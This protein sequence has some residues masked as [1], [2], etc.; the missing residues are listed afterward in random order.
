MY[1]DSFQSTTEKAKLAGRVCVAK[2]LLLTGSIGMLKKTTDCS[3]TMRDMRRIDSLKRALTPTVGRCPWFNTTLEKRYS[4]SEV[5]S[6]DGFESLIVMLEHKGLFDILI[7]HKTCFDLDGVRYRITLARAASTDMWPMGT[8]YWLRDNAIIGARM[9]RYGDARR[10]RLGLALL[11][12][13]LSFIS[14]CAQLERFRT[15]I[16][17]KGNAVR[18]DPLAWPHIFAA[19]GG[20]LLT[21]KLEPW[22]HKQDAWQILSWYII[23]SI[24][25]GILSVADLSE[26]NREFLGLIIPFLAKI[27]FWR[28]ENSGSWEELPAVRASVRAWEH[29]LVVRLGELAKK[30]K[31]TF[32]RSIYLRERQHLG[33]DVKSLTFE[34]IVAKMN[35]RAS[36]SMLRDLPYE[37]PRYA[38]HDPRYR[39]AD[40]ALLYLLEIDYVAFL[41]QQAGRTKAWVRAMEK[42]ILHEVLRLRDPVVGG[43]ARYKNDSYQRTGFFRE[44]TTERL[45]QMYGGPSGD[46]SSDFVGR[47]A[48]VPKGRSA[49]WTHFVWQIASWSGER[50]LA[51]GD[52]SMRRLH[53]EFFEQ[54]MK[55]VTGSSRSVD[56]TATGRPRIIRIPPYRM[57]E[58]YIS[59]CDRS[60]DEIIFPS[61]HTPLNWSIAEMYA[62]CQVRRSV[63]RPV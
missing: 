7:E 43:F 19:V 55:L 41:A 34:E 38:K 22:A 54:G 20:N 47:D 30:R 63:L 62:A 53:D 56:Y 13:G 59:E 33:A 58:C 40:A 23:D 3:I 24:E 45:R 60:G 25:Q 8:H 16:R 39:E 35:R 5:S 49:V 18:N 42:R 12:S 46:A 1:I 27:S 51:T 11:T 28:C 57:P 21:K 61:P 37:S 14:S 10:K 48:I 36:R 15:V 17:S 32:L 2:D 52:S 29:L 4:G 31:F 26:K 6:Y 44:E 9:L 50:F